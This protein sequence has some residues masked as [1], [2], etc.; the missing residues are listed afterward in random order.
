M[1]A[2]WR[3][4][5]W[6]FRWWIIVPLALF[7]LWETA[8]FQA[9]SLRQ[10]SLDEIAAR[11]EPLTTAQVA[12]ELPPGEPNAAVAYEAAF[13]F[14][15]TIKDTDSTANLDQARALLAG[16]ETG[17]RLL[18]EAARIPNCVWPIDWA[19]S[20]DAIT[21]PHF[22]PLRN[23]SRLL[24]LHARVLNA[25]GKHDEA[26]RVCGDIF[27]MAEH[28]KQTPVFIGQLVGYAIQGI[29]TDALQECLLEDSPSPEVC[30]ELF[31]QLATVEQDEYLHRSLLTERAFGTD[32]FDEIRRGEPAAIE[33]ITG[34]GNEPGPLNRP[35][36]LLY[37]TVGRPVFEL[38]EVSYL[39]YMDQVITA[40]QLAWPESRDRMAEL[41]GESEEQ[42]EIYLL[43]RTLMPV[44][45]RGTLSKDRMTADFRAAQI[46]LALKA[47]RTTHGAYPASLS[48]L[49]AADWK[50]SLD[51]FTS[52]PY[53]YRRE[54][55]GFIVYSLG[56][57]GLDNRGIPHAEGMSWEDGPY[58]IVFRCAR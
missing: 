35:V 12:P 46:A 19:A 28:A 57:N 1:G 37:R 16:Q 25:D 55:E 52:K 5:R 31:D 48:A 20:P 21:F 22:G 36:L 26:V 3:V 15:P 53:I 29:G 56:P 58:D 27:Q 38:D 45:G 4:L 6:G 44:F 7:L 2:F 34:T 43:S 13:G 50:I 47:Y 54:G 32:L 41:A 23:G 40:S 49:E 42:S 9:Q 11:G 18:R 14:L 24:A 39:E 51:P 30:R 33:V 17:L 10:A 8:L